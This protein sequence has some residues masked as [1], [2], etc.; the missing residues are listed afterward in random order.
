MFNFDLYK[1]YISSINS[2]A[3]S[4]QWSYSIIIVLGA[5]LMKLIL[6]PLWLLKDKL[7][8]VEKIYLEILKC[9]L[10]I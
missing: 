8:A 3:P 6:K 2:K 1:F 7:N 5:A 9:L 10:I 4:Y